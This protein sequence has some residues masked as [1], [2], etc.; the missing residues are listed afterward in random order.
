MNQML[1]PWGNFTQSL[2]ITDPPGISDM[3]I[4]MPYFVWLNSLDK[5]KAIKRNSRKR[6]SSAE[7]E[8]KS[9]ENDPI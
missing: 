7:N 8:K 6:N 2:W 5:T 9:L 1:E 3:Q 4:G